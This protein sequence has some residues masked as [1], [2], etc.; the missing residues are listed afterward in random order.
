M[1]RDRSININGLKIAAE[2]LCRL[3]GETRERLVESIRDVSPGSAL[4]IESIIVHELAPAPT[5][6]ESAPPPSDLPMT[7][8][9]NDVTSEAVIAELV[10]VDY[11][12]A[13][14]PDKIERLE[15]ARTRIPKSAE[16]LYRARSSDQQTRR[17]RIRTQ[18]A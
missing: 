10:D 12:G 2:I 16:E 14:T 13:L 15:A 1:S 8:E 17:R 3:P 5:R 11:D 18:L 4:K 9:P 7:L 6:Q